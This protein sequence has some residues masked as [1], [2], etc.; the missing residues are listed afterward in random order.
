[1]IR[2]K[3]HKYFKIGLITSNN[4]DTDFVEEINPYLSF[5]FN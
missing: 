1:M 3:M 4:V 5:Y 2:W